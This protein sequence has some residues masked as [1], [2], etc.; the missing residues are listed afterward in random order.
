MTNSEKRIANSKQRKYWL[1]SKRSRWR[2][3]LW[4]WLV[5]LVTIILTVFLFITQVYSFLAP[6]QK[7][8]AEVLVLE[9]AVPDYILD[10]AMKEFRE[11]DYK[12]L[13][14]TG[15]PLEWGHLLI[16]YKNTASVA[17]SS[18]K[19][20][21]FDSTLLV[22]VATTEIRN[23]RTFNSALEFAHY[24]RTT[25]PEMKRINLMSYGAHSRR[26]WMMFREALG[27]QYQVGIISIPS[28]YYGNSNWWKSSKGFRE[29]INE[30]LGYIF[31]KLFL[32]SLY[33][34]RGSKLKI[35]SSRFK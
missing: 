35:Q 3:N 7:V 24:I 14:T 26:S 34:G 29:V 22:A 11:G 10:S 32:R 31:V 21:G 1:I 16:D 17:A 12:L 5:I 8:D 2:L 20:L 28:F 23:N 15:T 30:L 18:L 25:H 6:T 13:V 27:D 33:E 19:R 4:G 9:G